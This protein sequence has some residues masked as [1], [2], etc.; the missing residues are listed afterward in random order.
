MMTIVLRKSLTPHVPA[1]NMPRRVYI[2]RLRQGRFYVGASFDVTSRYREH[3]NGHGTAFTRKFP[4]VCIVETRPCVT[5]FEED[6][7]VKEMMKT[8]GIDNVRGGTYSACQL[9]DSQIQALQTE[10]WGASNRCFRCGSTTHWV[11]ECPSEDSESER[12]DDEQDSCFRCGRQ[13]HW[14]RDCYARTHVDGSYL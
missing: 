11:Q 2:L 4:P 3:Q 6:M 8:H 10:I 14:V 9:S 5:G 12:G 7:V 13:G 1:G